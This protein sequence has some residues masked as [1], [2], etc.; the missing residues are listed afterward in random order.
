[1][2]GFHIQYSDF[3]LLVTRYGRFLSYH[4]EKHERHLMRKAGAIF[5]WLYNLSKDFEPDLL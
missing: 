2:P 4:S 5:F 1:M 3:H